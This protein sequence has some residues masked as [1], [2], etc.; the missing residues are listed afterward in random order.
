M[1][2]EQVVRAALDSWATLD[3]EKIVEHFAPDAV[4]DPE[5]SVALGGIEEI[6]QAVKE[7][8]ANMTF[9][10]MKLRNIAVNGNTVLTERIASFVLD[11]ERFAVPVMGT[12]EVANGKI[13]A[14]RDYYELGPHATE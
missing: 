1:D 8:T 6:R 7:Y 14:W 12:I 3:V 4:W 9:A 5:P 10:Q 2:T 13:V 11:G